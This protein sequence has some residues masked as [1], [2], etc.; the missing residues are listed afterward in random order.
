LSDRK[1]SPGSLGLKE[2]P[3]LREFRA[4]K[5][6]PDHRASPAFQASRVLKGL[7]DLPVHKAHKESPAEC[8]LPPIFL[9]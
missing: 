7:L 9:P 5:V 8:W 3:E 1:A 4:F 6:L 2:F